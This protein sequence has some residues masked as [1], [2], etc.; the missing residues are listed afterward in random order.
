MR[1]LR[2]QVNSSLKVLICSSL[3]LDWFPRNTSKAFKEGR[4]R[5]SS[6]LTSFY[7][8]L[9]S[10][11][12]ISTYSRES[13]SPPWATKNESSRWKTLLSAYS[14][15]TSWLRPAWP[16]NKTRSSETFSGCT[17]AFSVGYSKAAMSAWNT[18]SL[19]RQTPASFPESSL[20][21]SSSR[22]QSKSLIM[23]QAPTK[24]SR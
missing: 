10:F 16:S 21:K 18:S 20:P 22:L 19:M 23:S 4:P 5:L 1:K 14:R 2:G 13:S 12:R 3:L 24:L 17:S 7:P 11:A 9:T 6:W 8:S 15:R